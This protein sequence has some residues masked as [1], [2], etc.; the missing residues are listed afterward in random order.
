MNS[1]RAYALWDI[2]LTFIFFLIIYYKHEKFIYILQ[3]EK[4]YYE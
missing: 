4:I 2:L 3:K 1:H